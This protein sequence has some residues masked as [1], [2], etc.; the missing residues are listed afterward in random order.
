[1]TVRTTFTPSAWASL[2]TSVIVAE[3]Q[4]FQPVP[5]FWSVPFE[6]AGTPK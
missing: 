3:A 5:V 6:R 4:P 2:M 1:M